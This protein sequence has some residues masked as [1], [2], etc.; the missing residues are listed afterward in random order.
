MRQQAGAHGLAAVLERSFRDWAGDT[1]ER[2][3]ASDV[4]NDQL[5]AAALTANFAGDHDNWRYFSGL[6][7]QDH[8]L[9][10]GRDSDPAVVKAG[11][12]TLRLAGAEEAVKLAATRV[13][14][15]GPA[16]AARLAAADITLGASTRTTARANLDLLR[17]TGPVLDTNTADAAVQWIL[18]TH[19]DPGPFI[20]RT[21]A[22]F[23]VPS[24]LLDTLAAVLDSSLL[25]L[26]VSRENFS[27]GGRV[28]LCLS[29]ADDHHEQFIRPD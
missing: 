17:Y 3:S 27:P 24:R 28:S 9:R 6:L 10:L 18:S 8:L 16:L 15:D 19:A 7:G 2:W 23:E 1:A 14:R 11:L 22:A 29:A 25:M 26:R 12:G 4:A 13:V 20:A 21:S 5:L